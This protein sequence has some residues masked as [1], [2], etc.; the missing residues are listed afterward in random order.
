[1]YVSLHAL[2]LDVYEQLDAIQFRANARTFLGTTVG[3]RFR[4]DRHLFTDL[5]IG[6]GLEFQHRYG[7]Q[8][9][10]ISAPQPYDTRKTV[11]VPDLDLAV[12]IEF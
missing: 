7:R 8:E 12:G 9:V 4:L 6:A 10:G 5:G 1:M 3:W 2:F 11:L